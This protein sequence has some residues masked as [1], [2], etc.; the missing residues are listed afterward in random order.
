MARKG[1][2]DRGILQR[3][4]R[5]GW[6]VRIYANGRERWYRCDTKSQAKTLYC[7]LKADLREEKFFPEKYERRKE[8]SVRAWIDRCLE[9]STNRGVGNERRY[10]RRWSLMLGKRLLTDLSTQDLRLIQAKM[11]AKTKRVG[12]TTVTVKRQWSD[13]TINR[14]FAFLRHVLMLAVQDGKLTRNPLSGFR[15][16]PEIR[17]TRFLAEEELQ[18]LQG[19]MSEEDWKLVAF[20]IETGLR[21]GE[22]FS[23]RWDQVDLRVAR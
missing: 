13:A 6:W 20:A 10:G 7:R 11:R 14:H 9:G 21:R 1:G 4:G 23:L 8:I 18:R 17:R 12:N 19:I 5:E 3:K 2:K 22:Q 15:F 16:L